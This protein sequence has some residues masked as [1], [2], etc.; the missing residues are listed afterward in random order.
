MRRLFAT[1][2]SGFF[3]AESLR[4]QLRMGGDFKFSFS[5]LFCERYFCPIFFFSCSSAYYCSS[6]IGC[7]VTSLNR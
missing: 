7:Y 5:F 2:Q 3:F 1:T 6:Y 4:A